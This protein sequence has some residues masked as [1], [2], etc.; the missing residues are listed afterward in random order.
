[1]AYFIQFQQIKGPCFKPKNGF[2]LLSC[3][4]IDGFGSYF[5]YILL[6]TI[7]SII[8]MDIHT[9]GCHQVFLV[10]ILQGTVLVHGQSS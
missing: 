5:A 2:G 4:R 7:P 3:E 8:H 10:S 1:M 9:S 6:L